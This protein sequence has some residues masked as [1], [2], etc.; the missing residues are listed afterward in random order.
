MRPRR[1]VKKKTRNT[2]EVVHGNGLLGLYIGASR[3]HS[4]PFDVVLQGLLILQELDEDMPEEE[5][6]HPVLFQLQGANLDV[7][8]TSWP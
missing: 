1:E 8:R 5:V 4:L 2:A 6:L 7:R 3:K